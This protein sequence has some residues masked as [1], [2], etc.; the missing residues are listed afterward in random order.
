VRTTVKT[1]TIAL[2]AF[3]L[4]RVSAIAQDD[5]KFV[6]YG[7]ELKRTCS[8]VDSSGRET[9][10][11]GVCMGYILGVTAMTESCQR[12]TVTYG[13]QVDV[14]MKYLN[15]HPGELDKPSAEIICRAIIEAFPCPR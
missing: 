5:H 13:Q 6:K 11:D 14:V 3:V 12:P 9:F 15:E 10:S 7:N 1:W 8:H 2:A 4:F